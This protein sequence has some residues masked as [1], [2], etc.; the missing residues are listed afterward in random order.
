MATEVP[1]DLKLE[2]AHIL[3][4]DV[5]A[6]STLLMNEQ[7]DLMSKLNRLVRATPSFQEAAAAGQLLRLPTGDG[8]VLVFL[9]DPQAPLECAMEMA[10]EL[11]SH[12][13]IQL[14]MGI[15]SGPIKTIRDVN[16]QL[17]VTGAGID[18]AQRVMDCGDAGHILISRRAADDLAPSSRWNTCLHDLGDCEIKHGRKVSLYN[19]YTDEIGNPAIPQK[20][21]CR[22][23][24]SDT[25]QLATTVIATLA[26]LAVAATAT[27]FSL[28]HS[29]TP[30][31]SLAVLPFNDVSPKKNQEYLSEGITEEIINALAKVHGLSVV[32]RT[33]SFAIK[34]QN[35][36]ARAIGKLLHV[37]HL[38]EGSVN[39]SGDR[40]RIETQLVNVN[41]GYQAWSETYD[42]NEK[43]ILSLQSDVAQKVAAA[44]QVELRLSESQQ[45][46]RRPTYNPEAYDL[47]LRG[48]YLLNKRTTQAIEG[49]RSLFERAIA[50]DPTF[51][52]GHAGIA[53]AEILLAKIG[54]IPANE[55]AKRAW[56]QVNKALLLNDQLS[57]GYVSRGT[58]LTD[59][60]WNWP[61]AEKDFQKALELNPSNAAAHHWYAR[62]L[63]E[64]GRSDAA[65]REIAAAERLD[66]LSPTIRV[67]RAK[68]LVS[69]HKPKEAIEDCHKALEME[70]TF[71][72]AY[73]LLG[74]SYSLLHNHAQAIAAAQKYVE[75]SKGSGWAQLELAYAYAAAGQQAR[76][77]EIL[78]QV[79]GQSLPYSPY[80]MATIAAA[81]HDAPDALRWLDKALAG[82]SVD[83]VW[84][85]VDPR[86]DP[87]RSSPGFKE[88]L[89]ELAPRRQLL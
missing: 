69:A 62:H 1:S 7:S 27:Y 39:H 75:L 14:R 68:I 50:K 19:F 64:L 24:K 78:Q 40:Y 28:P 30:P 51:A 43:D 2:I 22:P 44:L 21:K 12:P 74:Q 3:T 67:T 65:L 42:S 48:R 9:A 41:D 35:Q 59:F 63:A 32:A 33:S 87:V 36:D 23:A 4:I 84:L 58:L 71:A 72:S 17:N 81:R 25:S 66:P 73:S 10:L 15:H 57:D 8:M 85:R 20:V 11:R 45:I 52:L 38:L 6:Y 88:R 82:R 5:V 29:K 61:A 46:A 34:N 13:E 79:Q 83:V 54:A 18:M 77:Q 70:P 49:G 55:G 31:K 53:D 60:D 80:D 16:D 26:L 89:A 37:N 86:L 56:P 76:A 47:Y